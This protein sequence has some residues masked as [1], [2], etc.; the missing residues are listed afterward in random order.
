MDPVSLYDPKQMTQALLESFP[1]RRFLSGTFFGE[2]TH[3]T[4]SFQIDIWKG[5][6]RLAPVVHPRL[7]GKVVDREKFRTLEFTPPYLKPKKVTTADMVLTRQP[8]EIVYTQQGANTPALRAAA[9]LGADMAEMDE[10]IQR[11]IEAMASEALFYGRVTVKGEGVDAVVDYDFE[12]THTP[13]LLTTALWTASTSDPIKN[14]RDWKRLISKDAGIT[15]TDVILGTEAADALLSNEKVL[16]QLDNTR[17]AL[18]QINPTEMGQGVTYLGRLTS[19][20]MDLWT[21]DEWYY[22]ETTDT[23]KPMV[24]TKS[25]LV[26]SRAIRATVHYGVI[27][28]IEAGQFATRA[29]AKSWITK[30]PSARWV[31]VQS[32]PL[33]VVHQVNGLVSAVV[34]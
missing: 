31:L 15:A 25:V 11:R 5:S 28:D 33:P 32:A 10:S 21:Y 19:V 18:G 17:M 7:A 20:G 30:D 22:D 26:I 9:I 4:K 24:P 6:R 29:F 1:A 13:T 8:G 14:L 23:E 16:K 2:E 3:D 27:Q 12:A 34:V